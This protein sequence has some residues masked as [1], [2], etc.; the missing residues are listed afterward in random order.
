[1]FLKSKNAK[2]S[3]EV[4]QI[5]IGGNPS[6]GKTLLMDAIF[7]IFDKQRV[8]A[9]IPE[10]ARHQL[11]GAKLNL[12]NYEEYDELRAKVA[13][14][15]EAVSN[16]EDN[17]TN[18]RQNTYVGKIRMGKKEKIL[19][20][21]NL[22]GEMFNAYF[23]S[24]SNNN[25]ALF[26][27]FRD[28]LSRNQ[29]YM[30]QLASFYKLQLTSDDAEEF[31]KEL[32]TEFL[33]EAFPE[34]SDKEHYQQAHK[35]FEAF[36][37]YYKA[38][39]HIYC[40]K[41]FGRNSNEVR[42]DNINIGICSQE[43]ED[44]FKFIICFTQFDKI[45]RGLPQIETSNPKVSKGVFRNNLL[46]TKESRKLKT[47]FN[48]KEEINNYWEINAMLNDDIDKREFKFVEREQWLRLTG[49]IGGGIYNTFCTSV[50]LN[51][52]Q[53]IFLDF[54]NVNE[55]DKQDRTE[56]E[57]LEKKY[58][59][60]HNNGNRCCLSVLELLLYVLQESGLP[61]QDSQVPLPPEKKNL[62]AIIRKIDFGQS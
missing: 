44:K 21:R 57:I 8:P 34:G 20:V 59:T 14:T 18:W 42:V 62:D 55:K 35:N 40:I 23:L 4:I 47:P 7:S 24:K 9:Y 17:E 41:S 31:I 2:Q 27:K 6:S 37:F 33:K 10:D 25:K 39:F 16:T 54:L 36:T 19:L 45:V 50:A 60:L 58:W 49:S 1:M 22:P 51:W 61:T 38:D 56:N 11:L 3:N 29:N 12:P 52:E 15:I 13:N 48:D 53:K 5:G 28:F 30:S 26:Y 32:K 46:S 43:A